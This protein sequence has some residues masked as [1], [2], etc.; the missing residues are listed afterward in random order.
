[1][2]RFFR[3]ATLSR[4]VLVEATNETEAR[5]LGETALRDLF[6]D[7]MQKTTVRSVALATDDE[8][9]FWK[10]HHDMLARDRDQ[11]NENS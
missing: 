1:M 5:R 8:I 6:P 11:Q 9:E 2:K 10:W 3:V 4:Y 7:L